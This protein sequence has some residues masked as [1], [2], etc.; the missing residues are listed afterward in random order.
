M[1]FSSSSGD[2]KPLFTF[3]L[4]QQEW[5][6]IFLC[7]SR[8]PVLQPII[9]SKISTGNINF[10]RKTPQ[11]NRSKE[12][13][14]DSHFWKTEKGE[15][16]EWNWEWSE[17]KFNEKKGG[18][19]QLGFVGKMLKAAVSSC[20]RCMAYNGILLSS[21]TPSVGATFVHVAHMHPCG[22]HSLVPLY[23]YPITF[24][25]SSL[26][27]YII[28]TNFWFFNYFFLLKFNGWSQLIWRLG[29]PEGRVMWWL[30]MIESLNLGKRKE[31]H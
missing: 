2:H 19:N 11:D 13:V 27:S 15:I 12:R 29:C 24:P 1:S 10:W 23:T 21:L 7:L 14:S 26:P 4:L 28:L 8:K 9:P 18:P 31:P 16:N 17:I 6:P 30:I 3:C 5:C 25:L 22:S 20:K